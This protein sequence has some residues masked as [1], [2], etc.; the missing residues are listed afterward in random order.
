[1]PDP[2]DF[3]YPPAV[4]SARLRKLAERERGRRRGRPLWT[5]GHPLPT[6]EE[7]HAHR[8][9]ELEDLVAHPWVGGGP[10]PE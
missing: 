6:F 4:L 7:W 8:M 9:Q 5:P 3:N 10:V 1:M 2:R